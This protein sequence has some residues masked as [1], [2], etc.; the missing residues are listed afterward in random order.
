MF[1]PEGKQAVAQ[2]LNDSVLADLSGAATV[3]AIDS[4]RPVADFLE[5][6]LVIFHGIYAL[7]DDSQEA[8][9]EAEAWLG[10]HPMLQRQ[11]PHD[12]VQ[13]WVFFKRPDD[14]VG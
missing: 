14:W 5:D 11:G 13:S 10:S 6:A 4:R 9:A 8:L 2:R 3:A 7:C 1:D 12:Y